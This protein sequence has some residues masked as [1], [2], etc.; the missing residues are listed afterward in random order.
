M[1]LQ[2]YHDII[3]IDKKTDKNE[4]G[5]KMKKIATLSAFVAV[6]L[7]GGCGNQDASCRIEVQKDI[8]Q[9]NFDSAISKLNGSCAS[10][11]NENDRLYNLATAY[12][13]KAGYGVSDVIKVMVEADNNGND[14]TFST[15]IKSINKNKKSAS[16]DLL[17]KAKEYFMQSLDPSA[18]DLQ[19]IFKNYCSLSN[20][21]DDPRVSNACFYVGF[22]EVIRTSVTVG[23]LTKN[24][25][26]VVQAIDAGDPTQ[27]PIDMKVNLDALSWTIGQPVQNGSTVIPKNITTIKGYKYLPL[28][29]VNSGKT[30]YRLAD[31]NAP[32]I[33][34]STVLTN[35]YCTVDGNTT[36]CEG[37]ENNDGSIDTTKIP[38]GT[39]CYACPVLSEDNA[40]ASKVTDLLVE[41]LNDGTDSI[42]S[43]SDDPDIAQSVKDFKKEV[44]GSE[45]GKVTA[46]D[47]I[48][49]LNAYKK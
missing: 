28:V 12:M 34:S 2:D 35:G 16:L 32:N 19:A 15:F 38:A 18:T 47:I 36:A 27:V 1:C 42:L 29:I 30:F 4:K 3:G 5:E 49:Y 25:D 46:K 33:Y 24:I 8:D 48:D 23:E 41:T 40:S 39:T 37:I 7:L 20:N 26:Q 31:E 14:S 11:F 44:T 9:G 45:Y 43:I 22:N 17:Q 13:G 6:L 10:A 21:V